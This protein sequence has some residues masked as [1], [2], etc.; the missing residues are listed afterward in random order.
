MFCIY[1]TSSIL[2]QCSC[3]THNI[4]IVVPKTLR[5]SLV[6]DG[7]DGLCCWAFPVQITHFFFIRDRIKS[8]ENGN[9]KT[10]LRMEAIHVI[11]RDTKAWLCRDT[12]KKTNTHH[13]R[14]SRPWR[15]PC[16][17]KLEKPNWLNCE[18]GRTDVYRLVRRKEL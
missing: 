16:L 13:L 18:K 3:P 15:A 2:N 14:F 1:K 5:C 4:N 8:I 12:K 17:R 11:L 9:I 10:R 6:A 7:L